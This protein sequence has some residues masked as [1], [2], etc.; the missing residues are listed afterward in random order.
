LQWICIATFLAF[1]LAAYHPDKVFD[2]AL[3]NGLV[4][5]TI[6]V[7]IFTYRRSLQIF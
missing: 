7:L 2:W 6:P 4:F 5:C 3:E 1:A